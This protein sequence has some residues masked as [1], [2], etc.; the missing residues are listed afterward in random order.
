MKSDVS[1]C[2]AFDKIW[3][4]HKY[5]ITRIQEEPIHKSTM[6]MFLLFKAH[7]SA[8]LS[9]DMVTNSLFFCF[10][11]FTNDTDDQSVEGRE[12]PRQQFILQS[13]TQTELF[14]LRDF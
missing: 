11:F 6:C 14:Q 4:K 7:H 2:F 1:P 8:Y 5:T 12:S 13:M 3:T 10:F 9:K